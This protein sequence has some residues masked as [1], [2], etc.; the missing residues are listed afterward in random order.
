MAGIS[1]DVE[2]LRVSRGDF[3]DAFGEVQPAFGVAEEEL[4]GVIQNG[5]IHYASHVDVRTHFLETDYE[6]MTFDR[7]CLK[8]DNSSLSKFGRRRGHRSLASS[9]MDLLVLGR[10]HWRPLLLQ[11]P[12]TLSSNSY[13][14]TRWSDSRNLRRSLPS[15]RCSRIAIRV[16]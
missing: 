13:H 6:L 9:Y 8:P 14:R 5:I 10:L 11:P 7:N 3:L 15:T 2:N 1:D 16:R 12:A 4:Q